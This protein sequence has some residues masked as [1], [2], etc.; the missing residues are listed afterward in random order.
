VSLVVEYYHPKSKQMGMD[1]YVKMA[2]LEN[3]KLEKTLKTLAQEQKY[4]KVKEFESQY[5]QTAA[6]ITRRVNPCDAILLPGDNVMH[7][8][9]QVPLDKIEDEILPIRQ[10]RL[11][12]LLIE[13][14]D[15]LAHLLR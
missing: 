15:N 11:E 3:V 6:P 13:N 12:R 14:E 2:K 8:V 10:R 5:V 9:N 7:K 1:N 4:P